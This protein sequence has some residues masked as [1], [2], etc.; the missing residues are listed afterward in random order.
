MGT[1]SAKVKFAG[2]GNKMSGST[3]GTKITFSGTGNKLSGS[4][5]SP[6]AYGTNPKATGNRGTNLQKK[7]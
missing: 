6:K 5:N 1:N 3:H 7:G 2:T 4:T